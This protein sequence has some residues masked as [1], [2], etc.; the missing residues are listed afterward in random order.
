MS[1]FMYM[2]I[3]ALRSSCF[4]GRV[5]SYRGSA[6]VDQSGRHAEY[7]VEHV[8]VYVYLEQLFSRTRC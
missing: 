7:R 2:I 5:V 1:V 3:M 4:D 8:V 6:D